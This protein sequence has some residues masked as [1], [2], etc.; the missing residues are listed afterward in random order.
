MC[1]TSSQ[2]KEKQEQD[3]RTSHESTKCAWYKHNPCK[4]LKEQPRSKSFSLEAGKV[5]VA[6]D[7]HT[8]I[9][10]LSQT[11]KLQI[12]WNNTTIKIMP[13]CNVYV[14]QKHNKEQ[15]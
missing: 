1:I 4:Q 10:I 14:Q 3:N 11:M 9:K 2:Q 13:P 12:L 15:F 7:F 6:Q 5:I 8:I